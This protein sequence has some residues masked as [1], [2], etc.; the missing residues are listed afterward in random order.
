M[1]NEDFASLRRGLREMR[2]LHDLRE[3]MRSV[4]AAAHGRVMRRYPKTM[5]RL[6]HREK[7]DE[8]SAGLQAMYGSVLTERI[9]DDIRALVEKLK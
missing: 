8:L 4:A 7:L 3:E 2:A 1:T 6:H 5:A 9:P